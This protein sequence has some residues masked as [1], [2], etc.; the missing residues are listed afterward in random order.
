MFLNGKTELIIKNFNRELKILVK[1][2]KFEEAI[3]I[4]NKIFRLERLIHFPLT[5]NDFLFQK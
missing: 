2:E 1:K 4:R 5:N 3:M